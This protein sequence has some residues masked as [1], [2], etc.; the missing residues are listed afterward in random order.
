MGE[1]AAEYFVIDD[2]RLNTFA[3]TVR[4]CSQASFQTRNPRTSSFVG[5]NSPLI[6]LKICSS[7]SFRKSGGSGAPLACALY[8]RVGAYVIR[9]RGNAVARMH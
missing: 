1:G 2:V 9:S 7:A 6:L 4:Q 8:A 5:S 3:Y